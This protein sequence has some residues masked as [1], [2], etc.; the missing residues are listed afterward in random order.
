MLPATQVTTTLPAMWGLGPCQLPRGWQ[1]VVP[2]EQEQLSWKVRIRTSPCATSRAPAA[3]ALAPSGGC[4]SPWLCCRMAEQGRSHP[5]LG[6]FCQ[7][8]FA[9]NGAA[10]IDM[11]PRAL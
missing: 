3:M 8:Q 10:R 2:T 1:A 6:Y 11:H 5:G 7:A 9:P 4:S